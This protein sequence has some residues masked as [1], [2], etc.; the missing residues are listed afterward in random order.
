MS[1]KIRLEFIDLAK[2]FCIMLVVMHHMTCH[3]DIEIPYRTALC[4]FRM[5]FYFMLSGLFF[6]TYESFWGFLKRKVNK[7]LIPFFF[8][9]ISTSV[10]LPLFLKIIGY[11]VQHADI[12][13]IKS[14]YAFIYPMHQTYSNAAIWF[15]L[16]LFWCNV[17]FYIV[18][19]LASKYVYPNFIIV[20]ICI[21]LGGGGYVLQK[22]NIYLPVYWD[23]TLSALPFFCCG[24][25]LNKGTNVLQPNKYDKFNVFFVILCFAFVLSFSEDVILRSNEIKGTWITFLICGFLGSLGVVLCSKMIHKLP[26]VSFL[27]RYSIIILCTHMLVIQVV[28]TVIRRFHFSNVCEFIVVFICTMLSYFIIIPFC[29]K[30]FPYVTAQKDVIRV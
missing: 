15:L 7:L 8:F 12:V 24:Y 5:P 28:L 23:S 1:S 30:Y 25:I 26:G 29:K 17:L 19:L 27:G 4:S 22:Y 13:G 10:C 3:I 18:Y 6:K 11:D 9:Y 16:C 14:L 20:V 2:G 21:A